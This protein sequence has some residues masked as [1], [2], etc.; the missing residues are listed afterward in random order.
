MKKLF[1]T[2]FVIF[3]T[4][5]LFAQAHTYNACCRYGKGNVMGDCVCPG[6]KKDK[7]D[8]IKASQEETKQLQA[9]AAAE[10][11]KKVEADKR[12]KEI[13][14]E[15]NKKEIIERKNNT[16]IIGLPEKTEPGPILDFDFKAFNEEKLKYEVV[17]EQK[18]E[19]WAEKY[20]V[21]SAK[22]LFKAKV[23]STISK[24]RDIQCVGP[25][26]FLCYLPLYEDNH[27]KNKFFQ[28]ND[29][30][31]INS[32]GERLR[33]GAYDEFCAGGYI[34]SGIIKIYT[35]TGACLSYSDNPIY[36]SSYKNKSLQ[37]Y[38]K[39]FSKIIKEN[40]FLSGEPCDC[41]GN[42]IDKRQ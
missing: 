22:L 27:C 7:D 12:A 21:H 39:D 11:A 38:Y 4:S 8:E 33:V 19:N 20:G 34:Y 1:I 23:I 32:R 2:I 29:I 14:I 26:I 24:Y 42:Y 31:L 30:H 37:A 28:K 25:N 13:A 36:S 6:C 15:K 10:Q 16:I 17:Y 5:S 35:S 40:E 41:N 18:E 3:L 9:K